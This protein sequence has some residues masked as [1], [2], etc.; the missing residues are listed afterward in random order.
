MYT[1]YTCVYIYIHIKKK[2]IYIYITYIYVYVYI[3]HIYIYI[4]EQTCRFTATVLV[5]RSLS[6]RAYS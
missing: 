3:M 4:L 1:R 5:G 6:D 2:Y